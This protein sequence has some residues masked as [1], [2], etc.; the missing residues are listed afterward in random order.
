MREHER[1]TRAQPCQEPDSPPFPADA[2]L[3][4]LTAARLD[5][6]AGRTEAAMRG[7]NRAL[8][9]PWD[10]LTDTDAAVNE[11]HLM[12]HRSVTRA[13]EESVVDG[14]AWLQ[15]V[16]AA[17]ATCGDHARNEM[18]RTLRVIDRDYGVDDWARQRIRRRLA[19]GGGEVAGIDETPGST[20]H[21][22]SDRR[23]MVLELLDA[24]NAFE[25][26]F[27]HRGRGRG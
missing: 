26:E 3:Q 17:L 12:F 27:A 8:R 20:S 15:A 14:S 4:L 21:P 1:V 6:A 16:E 5:L 11:A 7:V 13:L 10:H 19:P 23:A 25:V 18:L 24:L 22:E 9:L 2:A